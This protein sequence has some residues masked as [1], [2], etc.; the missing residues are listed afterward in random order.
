M[1]AF[2]VP[3]VFIP[4]PYAADD[5]QQRNVSA[6]ERQGAAVLIDNK[7]VDGEK[8]EA[9]ILSLLDDGD[10]RARMSS[11][12]REWSRVDADDAAARHIRDVIVSKQ[13][14]R[15]VALRGTLPT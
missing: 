4:Y 1:A 10:R 9:I 7:N 8:L 12:L 15:R 3:S 5:H 11:R 13:Q 14:E 2:G 6:L